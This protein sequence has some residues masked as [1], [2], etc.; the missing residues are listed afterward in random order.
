MGTTVRTGEASKQQAQWEEDGHREP[1]DAFHPNGD[2][3]RGTE[4][5]TACLDPVGAEVQEE[6]L[7]PDLQ[8]EIQVSGGI[9]KS[10]GCGFP[11]T[12]PRGSG[13]R[14]HQLPAGPGGMEGHIP[15]VGAGTMWP[16]RCSPES[17]PEDQGASGPHLLPSITC[18]VDHM[19][20]SSLQRR[21]EGWTEAEC[22]GL[23]VPWDGTDAGNGYQ[24]AI[25][26]TQG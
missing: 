24:A 21:K 23:A 1:G 6:R 25:P 19:G 22:H 16:L 12:G 18:L 4:A 5:S 13:S 17:L 20:V 3:L 11:G 10:G 26:I 7:E 9:G 14:V 8:E 15:A 2:I